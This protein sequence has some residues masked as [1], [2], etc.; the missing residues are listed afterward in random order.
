MSRLISLLLAAA[1][2]VMPL[3]AAGPTLTYFGRAT[4][5]ITASDGFVV[6]LDPFAPGDHAAKANLVLVTHG[7][8]DHNA[9]HSIPLDKDCVLVA[10]A[11][12][13]KAK[14][15]RS[16][17]EGDVFQVGPVAVKVVPAYNRNHKRQ[18][19]VGYLVTV[20]GVT[21]YHAG[22][23][24]FI[25]EMAALAASRIDYALFPTDG[26]WNMGGEEARRCA[27]AVKATHALA[28]HSSPNGLYDAGNAAKLAGPD[29]LPLAPGQAIPLVK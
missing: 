17:K 3:G 7:H 6:Y 22:D 12:A 28:I 9:V 1:A 15:Y 2:S 25:P 21:L 13:L 23:T 19:S 8:D 14:G 4:V 5:R 26:Y 27:D 11:G 16:V 10:P 20:D 29:V 24:S 18:E